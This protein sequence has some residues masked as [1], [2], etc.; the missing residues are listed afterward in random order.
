MNGGIIGGDNP[1][2][3]N[4]RSGVWLA[5]DA[6]LPRVGMAIPTSGLINHLPLTSDANDIVGSLNLTNNNSVTFSTAGARFQSAASQFL[7]ATVTWP[8]VFTWLLDVLI[9]SGKYFYFGCQSSGGTYMCTLGPGVG[10]VRYLK[11]TCPGAS[12]GV[13]NSGLVDVGYALDDGLYH[14]VAISGYNNCA[15]GNVLK[16]G[17]IYCDGECV[18]GLAYYFGNTL[19]TAFSIGR[20]GATTSGYGDGYARNFRAYN[21]ILTIDE[22]QR[23]SV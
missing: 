23:L 3:R 8:S 6:E 17:P 14:T 7:S 5:G 2:R 21:R 15:D 12:G 11:A 9:D 19:S 16:M 22:I 20:P 18:G 4:R 1:R 13:G 10:N